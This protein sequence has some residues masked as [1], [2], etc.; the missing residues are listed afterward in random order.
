MHWFVTWVLGPARPSDLKALKRAS[1][2]TR[3]AWA[4]AM[5]ARGTAGRA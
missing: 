5:Q 4:E 3:K 2:A 1:D